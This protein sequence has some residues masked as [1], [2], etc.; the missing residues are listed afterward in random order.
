MAVSP[1]KD[2]TNNRY[3]ALFH[4]GYVVQDEATVNA[5]YERMKSVGYEPPAPEIL[6][7]GGGNTY[8]FY[9]SPPGQ[10]VIEV[11]TP[12]MANQQS[13]SQLSAK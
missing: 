7:R 10:I 6:K 3:P 8:G 12:A 13:S 9:H 5:L 4:M 11:S 1:S 2:E